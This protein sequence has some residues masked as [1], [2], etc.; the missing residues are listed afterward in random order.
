MR[1]ML[2]AAALLVGLPAADAGPRPARS[3]VAQRGGAKK[4]ARPA[5]SRSIRKTLAAEG[6]HLVKLVGE[7]SFD[8][9]RCALRVGSSVMY[10]DVPLR[11]ATVS[12]SGKSASAE[13]PG[14]RRCIRVFNT[15]RGKTRLLGKTASLVLVGDDVKTARDVDA[16]AGRIRDLCRNR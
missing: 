10:R 2:I 6:Q 13:C 9:A 8:E 14:R 5:T 12:V 3:N 4:Q 1:F 15:R 11:D 7:A 16:T